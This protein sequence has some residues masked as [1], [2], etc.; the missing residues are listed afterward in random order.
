MKTEEELLPCPFCGGQAA[1]GSCGKH[2]FVNCVDCLASV[3]CLN[4]GLG[5][6]DAEA[7]DAWNRRVD[8]R[9][10]ISAIPAIRDASA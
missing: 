9:G 8:S 4:E 2:S 7:A 5:S 10:K 6:T 3:Q 1:Y